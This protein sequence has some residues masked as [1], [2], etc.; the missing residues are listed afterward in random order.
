[1]TKE[2][3]GILYV[4]IAGIAWGLSGTCGQYLMAR[5]FPPFLLTSVR[6]VIAGFCLS[7]IA[8]L[9]TSPNFIKLLKQPKLVLSIIGFSVIGLLLNQFSYLMAIRETNAGTATVLQYLCPILVLA[10]ACFHQKRL[11][12]KIESFSMLAAVSGTFLIATHGQLTQLAVTPSG[13]FWGLVAAFSYASY[14]VLPIHLIKQWG[15]LSVNGIGMFCTGL[16]VFPFSQPLAFD[17]QIDAFMILALLG[18]IGVG[19]ILTYTLF[20]AGASLIGP[21]KSSLLASIEP[22]SAVFFAFWLMGSQFYLLDLL[23]M[24][25]ILLGVVLISYRDLK[26]IKQKS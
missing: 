14:I 22:I 8:Y 3:R 12:T 15:S 9:K 18:I 1:M 17:W 21:V 24:A 19:T 6:M 2:G 5:G 10:Y 4:L 26:M 20:L 13:L 23:G 7:M 11:P 16:M 25:L